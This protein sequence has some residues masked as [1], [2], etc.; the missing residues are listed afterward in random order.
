MLQSLCSYPLYSA[1][2]CIHRQTH[3]S[4]TGVR[5]EKEKKWSG[6]SGKEMMHFVWDGAHRRFCRISDTWAGPWRHETWKQVQIRKKNMVTGDQWNLYV[7]SKPSLL[8]H[9]AKTWA[10]LDRGFCCEA[11]FCPGN[12]DI[13]S[14]Q[15]SS[16]VQSC[17]TLCDP[18]DCSTPGFSVHHQL[19]EPTQTHVHQVGDA[20]QPPYPLLSPSPPAFFP[21]I[22]LFPMSQFFASGGQSIGVSASASVLPMNTQHWS[23]LGWTGWISLQ[24]KGLSWVFSNTTA[25]KNQFSGPLYQ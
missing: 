8:V 20:I 1:I 11:H 2:S 9:T 13:I 21:G 23:P 7:F 19:L 15:F 16:V 6:N 10:Q 12:K 24:S 22:R 5:R 18:V 3:L 17:L 4:V 25:Q 14:G